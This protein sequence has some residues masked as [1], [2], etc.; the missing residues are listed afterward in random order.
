MPSRL[1]FHDLDALRR[2][3]SCT[4]SNAIELFE[5]RLRNEGFAGPSIRCLFPKL[6]PMVGHAATVKIRSSNP[7]PEGHFYFDRTDWWD[8]ILS[9]PAPRVVVIQDLDPVPGSGA[10]LGEVHCNILTALRCV[11]AVTNGAARDLPR[12]ES[13]GFH[14]FA[15]G[16]S[17]SH[18]YVHIVEFGSE[19]EIGNLKVQ[20]GELLH[21][22]AH[23]VLSIPAEIAAEI[24][25]AAARL[26]ERERKIIALCRS[27]EF[28]MEKLRLAV[29]E[30]V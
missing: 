2:L 29:K 24:P 16:I 17:V 28:S 22:D 18:S 8:Y 21:G 9:I 23:G 4:V 20:P 7:P 19:V 11:G 1:N 13:I 6:Q 15:S 25:Q 26:L 30:S 27:P 3:D 5:K 12:V 14:L 10:F